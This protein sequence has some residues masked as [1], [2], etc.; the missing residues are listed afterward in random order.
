[1]MVAVVDVICSGGGVM[2]S[3]CVVMT[4]DFVGLWL[5]CGVRLQFRWL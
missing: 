1:M 2:V 5:E 3:E 4:D